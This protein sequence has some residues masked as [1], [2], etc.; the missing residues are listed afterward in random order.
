M[1]ARLRRRCTRDHQHVQL[2]GKS[3]TRAAARYPDELVSANADV[4]ADVWP[5]RASPPVPW[6]AAAAED[7][8]SSRAARAVVRRWEAGAWRPRT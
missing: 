2:I 3:A 8:L 6:D 7:Y 4:T 5:R 1:M